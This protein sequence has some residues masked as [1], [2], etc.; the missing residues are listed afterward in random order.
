[1][2]KIDI[3]PNTSTEIRVSFSR[4]KRLGGTDKLC[5]EEPGYSWTDCLNS[6]IARKAGCSPR[7]ANTTAAPACRDREDL[8]QVQ[9][10]Y[11]RVKKEDTLTLNRQSGCCSKCDTKT[12]ELEI[13]QESLNWETDWTAEVFLEAASGSIREETEFYRWF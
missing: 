5:V 4:N 11:Q 7:W 9:F 3:K 10:W 6:Y 13:E 8:L 12:F 2:Q 1:M